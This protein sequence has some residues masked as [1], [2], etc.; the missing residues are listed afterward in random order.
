MS[1]YKIRIPRVLWVLLLLEFCVSNSFGQQTNDELFNNSKFFP[2]VQMLPKEINSSLHEYCPVM[3][4]QRN[5]LYYTRVMLI[6]TSD[7]NDKMIVVGQ[8]ESIY[9]SEWKNG[10]W[11]ESQRMKHFNMYAD[12]NA[13]CGISKEYN[14][15]FLYSGEKGGDIFHSERTN[16]G[17]SVPKIYGNKID[18]REFQEGDATISSGNDELYFTRCDFTKNG[19]VNIYRSDKINKK[20][21]V[22]VM[23]DS[24]INTGFD[25]R[26]PFIDSSNRYFFFSSRGHNSIGGYDIFV[27]I[28]SDGKFSEPINL[29]YPINSVYDDLYFSISNDYKKAYFSSNRNDGEDEDLYELD[30]SDLDFEKS[31]DWKRQIG[32]I[33]S[34]FIK[35]KGALP[36]FLKGIYEVNAG[37]LYSGYSD[38]IK[39]RKE[40]GVA[41]RFVNPFC[42]DVDLIDYFSKCGGKQYAANDYNSAITSFSNVLV[43]NRYDTTALFNRGLAYFYNKDIISALKDMD[44]AI[45]YGCI[46]ATN[47]KKKCLDDQALASFS[48]KSAVQYYKEGKFDMAI[49]DLNKVLEIIPNSIV[50]LKIRAEIKQ[51]KGDLEGACADW[52]EAF[53][54]GDMACETFIMENCNK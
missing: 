25:D 50:A 36:Y 12:N 31:I 27:S 9:F 45:S 4:F 13:V 37:D 14:T 38:L 11:T 42:L 46:A 7:F 15:L 8:S 6:R 5:I 47:F 19:D 53:K 52:T 24:N 29:G 49:S 21:S 32:Q 3:D 44:A 28:I 51:K 40:W 41:S 10:N 48:L 22:A 39:V 33:D 30:Y 54:L 20:W 1:F 35:S 26:C 16:K 23:L 18:S 43:I 17:W 34:T 2:K